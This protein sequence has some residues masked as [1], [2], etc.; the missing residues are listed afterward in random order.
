MKQIPFSPPRIDQKTID[1]VTEVL[2]SGWITTGPKTRELESKISRYCGSQATLCLNSWTNAAELVL[3]WFGVGPG[4]EVILPAYTYAAT[5]NIVIHVGAKPVLVD[6]AHDSFQIDLHAIRNKITANTKVIM[7]VDIGGM[8]CDYEAL[9]QLVSE[10]DV[11]KIFQPRGEQQ[12]KL[13][14][15]LVLADAAH[16]FGATYL[17]KKVGSQT[18]VMGFSFHAVKNLTTAEGGALTFNL[19]EP[20]DNQAVRAS[21][22]VSAL[23]GQSKDALTKTQAGQWRYD[24]VEAGYKCNLTDIQAAIGLV[25]MER[26]D[27]ETL[28]R[29]KEICNQYNRLLGGRKWF[30]PPVFQNEKAESCYHLYALRVQDLSEEDRD[31]VIRYCAEKGIALNVHFQPLPLL[32]FY[33]NLGYQMADYPNAMAQYSNE[34]SLPVYYNLLQEDIEYIVNH[35]LVAIEGKMNR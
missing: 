24:I 4:D 9:M 6:V 7:P 35:L 2:L 18:D 8:P 17:G 28:P 31:D 32:S 22:N 33:K 5:A 27:S 25:E 13:G 12:K 15:I 1:A 10:D 16:S 19:P 3:R 11:K 20:F 21:L 29:R 26:Y 14:R 30:L 23:H 34:I